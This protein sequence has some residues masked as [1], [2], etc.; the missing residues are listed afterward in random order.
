M[1]DPQARQRLTAE[2]VLAYYAR[3]TR[4][5]R[6]AWG[7][8]FHF[9]LY[10][11]SES[12]KEAMANTERLIADEGGFKP[13]MKVLDIGCGVGGPACTIAQHSGAHVTGISIVAD[14]LDIARKKAAKMGISHLTDFRL[15]NGMDLSFGDGEFDAIYIFEAGCHMPDKAAFYKGVARVLKPGGVFVGHEWMKADGISPE[16]EFK[17]CE[18]VSKYHGVPHMISPSELRTYCE[19]AGL[20]V[21]VSENAEGRRGSFEPNWRILDRETGRNLRNFAMKLMPAT[22]RMLTEGGIAVAQGARAGAFIIGYWRA[23]KPAAVGIAPTASAAEP[24]IAV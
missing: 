4:T 8:S 16:D 18:P 20:D 12:H 2:M 1:D 11:G 13:G 10:K 5:Y 14:H 22:L 17:Y 19:A 21:E 23:V 15:M 3:V 7:D 24:S 6:T 9:A